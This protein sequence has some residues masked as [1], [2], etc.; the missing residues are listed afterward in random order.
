MR[1]HT[2]NSLGYKTLTS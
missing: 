2:H 1:E